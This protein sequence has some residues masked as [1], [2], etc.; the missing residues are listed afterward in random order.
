MNIILEPSWNRFKP[1]DTMVQGLFV[2]LTVSQCH[3]HSA[4][5]WDEPFVIR[6]GRAAGTFR[7]AGGGAKAGVGF[8][9]LVIHWG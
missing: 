3:S 9:F 4:L 7:V 1:K 6:W 2:L 8:F 5:I